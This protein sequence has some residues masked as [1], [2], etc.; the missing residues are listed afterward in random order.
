M[1]S[2]ASLRWLAA[3]SMNARMSLLM[4][5]ALSTQLTT[6]DTALM[7]GSSHPGQVGPEAAF[8]SPELAGHMLLAPPRY[9]QK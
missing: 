7:N 1:A 3:Q 4:P 2:A 9:E 8:D 6:L 5:R